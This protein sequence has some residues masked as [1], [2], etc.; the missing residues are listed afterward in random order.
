MKFRFGDIEKKLKICR[1][2]DCKTGHFTSWIGHWRLRNVPTMKKALR[3]YFFKVKYGNL[4]L[5]FRLE[6]RSQVYLSSLLLY[7]LSIAICVHFADKDEC[8]T[9]ETNQCDA[10]A[11]CTNTR[12]SY[13]CRCIK[14]YQGDGLHCQGIFK[15]KFL[16][17]R[18]DRI[19]ASENKSKLIYV[20]EPQ[21]LRR[22]KWAITKKL[23]WA[24]GVG[25]EY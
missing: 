17:V 23:R 20:T 5:S 24:L 14:G 10:N 18:E 19:S 2:H 4:W 21:G 25:I 13:V 9:S 7:L 11:L 1:A 15:K 16:S 22:F 12:G 3:N 6:V 8:A